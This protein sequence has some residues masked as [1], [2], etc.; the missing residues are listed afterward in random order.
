MDVWGVG[1]SLLTSVDPHLPVCAAIL[2]LTSPDLHWPPL[3]C[4]CSDPTD[5]LSWPPL[6]PANRPPL[7]P[8]DLSVCAASLLRI[9]LRPDLGPRPAG[10]QVRH[11]QT[12]RPQTLPQAH[13]PHLWRHR[14]E[15]LTTTSAH[16][17]PVSRSENLADWIF[18][19]D[20]ISVN[21]ADVCV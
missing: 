15:L 10:L 4:L 2:P 16:D 14:G 17:A 9:L 11:L 20:S 18:V 8:V 19:L 6:T 1:W 7:T 21:N 12:A 5:D 3:T 13:Q